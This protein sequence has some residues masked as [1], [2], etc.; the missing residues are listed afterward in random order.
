M[1]QFSVF[2]FAHQLAFLALPVVCG[3]Q[4][5]VAERNSTLGSRQRANSLL[6]E[7]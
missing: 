6:R 5:R 4:A 1:K 7:M 2:R 3:N